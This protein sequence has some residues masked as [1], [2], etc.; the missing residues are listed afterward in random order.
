MK[1]AVIRRFVEPENS[2]QKWL[3]GVF[4]ALRALAPRILHGA[5]GSTV[6]RE[7]VIALT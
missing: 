3:E 6:V 4:A 7:R 1:C 5:Q 2:P